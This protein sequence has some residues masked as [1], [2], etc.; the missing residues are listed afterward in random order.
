MTTKRILVVAIDLEL[1][2]S[3]VLLLQS[4]GYKVD[5]VATDD[6]AMQLLESVDF[7]LVLLG[8]N[9]LLFEKRLDQ[10]IR[11]KY[12]QQLTLKIQPVEDTV[13]LYASRT[14]DSVPN[15]VIDALKEML[16]NS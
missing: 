15:H 2:H 14:T 1:G 12:P 10:R 11:Q 6:E 7:D 4:Q 8:R 3:R 9:S 13:S 16:A 5:H